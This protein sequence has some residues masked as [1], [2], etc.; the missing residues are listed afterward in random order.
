[1]RCNK[2]GYKARV[3][4]AEVLDVNDYVR[5]VIFNKNGALTEEEVR[6]NQPF[7]SIN[8]DGIIKVL[9]GLTSMEEVMRVMNI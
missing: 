8:Q 1:M 9:Q 3:A 5:D 7:I 6:K 2:T 4:L